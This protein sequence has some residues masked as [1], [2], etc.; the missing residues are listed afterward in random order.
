[1]ALVVCRRVLDNE[2][3]A[4]DAFLATFLVLAR[5]QLSPGRR[6]VGDARLP[7]AELLDKYVPDRP[8]FLGRYDGHMAA[9]N[10]RA[11]KLA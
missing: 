8:V 10:T 1:M 7:T 4:E 11:L 2:H 6:L 9:A 3:D 5:R